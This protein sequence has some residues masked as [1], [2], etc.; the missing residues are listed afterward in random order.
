MMVV[1]AWLKSQMSP[2][3]F[4]V[5]F[6]SLLLWS[7]SLR[8]R[9]NER[10]YLE[11]LAVVV[12]DA[13]AV[14]DVDAGWVVVHVLDAT[15]LHGETLPAHQIP[16][17][18]KK[19]QMLKTSERN[20]QWKLL[21]SN[22]LLGKPKYHRLLQCAGCMFLGL[23]AQWIGDCRCIWPD[24][25]FLILGWWTVSTCTGSGHG[26]PQT[27]LSKVNDAESK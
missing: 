13:A 21:L 15:D 5:C 7:I 12:V 2:F 25:N 16:V 11:T 23:L 20:R 4:L 10:G 24:F 6:W 19:C 22:P 17:P 9:S 27:V 3:D 8:R 26:R 1:K 18:P 14:E